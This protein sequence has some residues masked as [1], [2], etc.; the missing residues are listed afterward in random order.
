MKLRQRSHKS[1]V[2][3]KFKFSEE[4]SLLLFIWKLPR[5]TKCLSEVMEWR[6]EI[7]PT[8]TTW[9]IINILKTIFWLIWIK[10]SWHYWF[11]LI[12]VPLLTLLTIAVC[13][14]VFKL[15]LAFLG[16]FWSGMH[17]TCM[18]GANALQSMELSLIASPCSTVFLRVV[19]W[20]LYCLW[21]MLQN[22]LS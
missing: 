6:S 20:A 1:P 15:D 11:F 17:R 5:V 13:K 3:V 12:W 22:V 9:N 7:G 16:T 2:G 18:I 10:G 4:H 14:G 21:F 19:V 8:T